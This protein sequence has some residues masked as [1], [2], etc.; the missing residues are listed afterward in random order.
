[1]FTYFMSLSRRSFIATTAGSL[2]ALTTPNWSQA[3]Q[4]RKLSNGVDIS[5]LP[6][7][8]AAGGRFLTKAGKEIDGIALLKSNGVRVGRV[9]VFVNPTTPNGQLSRAISLAKRLK[10][11]DMEICVDLHYS[12]DWADPGSQ[13]VPALWPTNIADL[14]VQV[15]DHTTETLKSFVKAVAPPQWVQIGNEISNGFMWPL[16]HLN[17]GTEEGWQNFVTLYNAGD[18]ALREVLPQAKSV[19]HLDCGGDGDRIR[20]WL[21]NTQSRGLA[22]FDLLGLSY[23]C[24]WQ[25]SL[26]DLSN[27]L[28]VV[29]T[30]FKM[31]VLIAETAYPWS[32]QKFGNDV[33][34]TDAAQLA[35]FPQTPDGQR[36]YVAALERLLRS[37]P[38][39]RGVGFWWWE[40]LARPVQSSGAATLW[41]GGM[42]NSTLVDLNG[43]ALPS[44]QLF[45]G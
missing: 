32:S 36:N 7:V 6:D 20:W 41:N 42:A 29:T 44:L 38:A 1:L 17:S 4:A 22:K 3:K 12:D 2:V 33:I 19:L 14:E 35:G 26:E 39:N 45:N 30:E 15:I 40:G 10:A 25:G 28:R 23:Y 11:A 21:N 18:Y 9:R 16:G 13:V 8:E 5:W 37:Q 43:M 34:N 27:A 31:P 24:Q